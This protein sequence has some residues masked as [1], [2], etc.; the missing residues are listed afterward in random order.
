MFEH[1]VTRLFESADRDVAVFI[2]YGGSDHGRIAAS[3]ARWL[4][5]WPRAPAANVPRG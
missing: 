1:P 2:D 3:S 4:H 5:Q